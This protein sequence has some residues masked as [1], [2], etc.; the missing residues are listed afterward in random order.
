MPLN[1]A[2]D[3]PRFTSRYSGVSLYLSKACCQSASVSGGSVP[4][5]GCHSVIDNPECVSRVTPPTTI[6]AN[7]SAQ[8]SSSHAATAPGARGVDTSVESDMVRI[9]PYPSRPD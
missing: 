5:I 9:L 7:T 3:I 4:T 6:I 8:H 1:A 2:S